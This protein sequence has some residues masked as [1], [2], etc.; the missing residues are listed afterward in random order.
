MVK[1]VGKNPASESLVFPTLP[2]LRKQRIDSIITNRTGI[3]H[4][5]F[6]QIELS[7]LVNPSV[8]L[9]GSR[10]RYVSTSPVPDLFQLLVNRMRVRSRFVLACG[11]A[12]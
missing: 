3:I 5:H 7:Y 9:D 4:I 11:S 8:Q 6:A 2:T 12:Q 1:P 10:I